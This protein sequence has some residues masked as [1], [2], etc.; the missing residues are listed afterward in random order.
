MN[1]IKHDGIIH[2]IDEQGIHVRI[3]QMAACASCKVASQCQMS[4][5]KE[6]MVDVD[7]AGHQG[8]KVGDR[9]VVYTEE[10]MG[11][12]AVFLAFLLPFLILVGVLVLVLALTRNEGWA[13]LAGI[14]ALVPYYLSLFFRKDAIK[15][16]FQFKL[17][18]NQ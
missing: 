6:K 13:A 15:K 4:D 16:Q 17:E 2:T 8:L 12:K 7:A 1:R 11:F 18:T 10:S 5:K 14:I 3:V 9:V